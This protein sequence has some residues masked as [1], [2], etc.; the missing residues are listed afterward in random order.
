MFTP[1]NADIIGSLGDIFEN[2]KYNGILGGLIISLF[3]LGLTIWVNFYYIMRKMTLLIFMILGPLMVTLYLIPQTKQITSAWF[4]E[5]VGTLFV[6]SVHAACY[7]MIT[8]M[9]DGIG[10]SKPSHSSSIYTTY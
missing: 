3:M 2:I 7:W 6:Q 5:L 10:S 4:R 9:S 8:L 1:E